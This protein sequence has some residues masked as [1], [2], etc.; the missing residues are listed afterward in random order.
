ML[1][2]IN[3]SKRFHESNHQALDQIS[4]SISKGESLGIV[5]NSGS[6][7]STLGKII[8]NLI[9]VDHGDVLFENNSIFK[10]P[11]NRR[12]EYK[13]SV[14]MIF[15]DPEQTFNPQMSIL[16]SL[17]EPLIIFKIGNK[18]YC[19][20]LIHKIL[21][22]VGID[23]T[24]INKKPNQFSG[25][26]LQR[27]S[28]ARI[29]LLQPKILIADEP[30]SALDVSVQAQIIKLLK[31]LVEEYQLSLIFISHNLAIVE[32]IC[33]RVIVLHQGQLIEEGAV[34]SV[35]EHPQHPYT[36]KLLN[37]HLPLQP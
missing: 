23:P 25:G 8:L 20:T 9:D 10:L 33:H 2:V 26:Q 7:K 35:F 3:I 32:Q 21:L 37:A 30:V 6:G 28:I 19:L 4:F 13:R 17:M 16:Q 29:L 11:T 5:G 36:K 1:E 22:Q 18:E 15:Q 14:Q 24:S 12:L 34:S 31:S 27:L